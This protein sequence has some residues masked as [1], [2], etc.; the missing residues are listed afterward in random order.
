[1]QKYV[2]FVFGLTLLITFGISFFSVAQH[3]E[4]NT[5]LSQQETDKYIKEWLSSPIKYIITKEEAKFFKKL[6]DKKE[7]LRFINYFWLRRDPNPKTVINEFRNEFYKRVAISNQQFKIGKR[8]GWKSQRGQIYIVLGPPQNIRMGVTSELKRYQAWTYYDIPSTKIPSNYTLTFID[9]YGNHDYRVAYGSFFS[10]SRHEKSMDQHLLASPGSGMMPPELTS[11][12]GDINQLSIVNKDLELKDVPISLEQ[13]PDLPFKFYI[14][15]FRANKSD[16]QLLIGL[17]FRYNDV[18]F[19]EKEG[20]KLSPSIDITT[21]LRDQNNTPI[22][23][24]RQRLSFSLESQELAKKSDEIFQCWETLKA[25]PGKY[26]L[27]INAEDEI[28]GARSVL[29][30]DITITSLLEKELILS[31]VI[32]ADKVIRSPQTQPDDIEINTIWL[33][34]HQITANLDGIFYVGSQ[35][36][37][38]FQL[39]NL[40]ANPQ[41]PELQ[42]EINCYVTKDDKIFQAFKLP[43]SAFVSRESDE[44]L[45]S[46]CLPLTDFHPGEYILAIIAE[47]RE[48]NKK[49]YRRLK[50]K[51]I[52]KNP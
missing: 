12:I 15:S 49:S 33:M 35:L 29:E 25:A 11:A 1:M 38:F 22:D 41:S 4:H 10:K 31:E 48:L 8:K 44:I 30:K 7:K 14:T 19:I 16:T 3:A 9:F 52:E 2:L 6:K 39:I 27:N 42:A 47:D 17:S 34:G 24:S 45:A 18:A 13:R 43:V 51:V 5:E 28:S 36:C 21:S 26:F 50:F 37:F 20:G 23:F 32:L 40:Y 46:F